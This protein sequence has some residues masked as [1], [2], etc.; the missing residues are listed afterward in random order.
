ML[1]DQKVSLCTAKGDPPFTS[2]KNP[3]IGNWK[4]GTNSNILHILQYNPVMITSK[5]KILTWYKHIH[6][7]NITILPGKTCPK[8]SVKRKRWDLEYNSQEMLRNYL[9]IDFL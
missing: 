6:Y 7:M 1:P 3:S 5:R 4:P 8:I 2:Q 9:L